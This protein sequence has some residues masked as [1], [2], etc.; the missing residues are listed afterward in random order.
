MRELSWLRHI[1][2]AHRG[3]H[4]GNGIVP[5]NSISAFEAA[6]EKGYA[7]ELDIH[8]LKDNEIVV[9]HDESLWRMCGRKIKINDLT[10][11]DLESYPLKG[12][13]EG[14]PLLKEVLHV[15]DDRTPILIEIKSSSENKGI[16]EI[17]V[18]LLNAYKGRVA[19]QSFN[20]LYLKWLAKNAPS[21][22]RGQLSGSFKEE[23]MGYVTKFILRNYV[24]NL[25]AKPHFIAHEV[26]D[27]SRNKR[28][29]RIRNRNIPVLGWTLRDMKTYTEKE[30]FL[31][32]IIFENFLP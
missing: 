21:I 20:P 7:I 12:S 11:E 1:P 10:L 5:E 19:V 26:E 29:Q 23:P 15:V 13:G 8:L 14:I 28:V 22:P 2:I 18:S 25:W 3:L 6:I 9:F 31:D 30:P 32:N 4:S 24:L 27:L 16:L 17:L